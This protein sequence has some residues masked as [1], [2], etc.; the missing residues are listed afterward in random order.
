[1]EIHQIL[2]TLGQLVES[3]KD[4]LEI[5]RASTST[6]RGSID[7]HHAS[8]PDAAPPR[9]T[10]TT[11][12]I[13][14][15][16]A[17]QNEPPG[18]LGRPWPEEAA[19]ST[20]WTSPG[21]NDPV[22][23]PAR[24]GRGL[25]LPPA[26][27]SFNSSHSPAT[28]FQQGQDPWTNPIETSPAASTSTTAGTGSAAVRYF[29]LLTNDAVREVI[30]AAESEAQSSRGLVDNGAFAG[31]T[32]LQRA[33][34]IV[35][36]TPDT[37]GTNTYPMSYLD[38]IGLPARMSETQLWQAKEVIQLLPSEKIVF[39]NFVRHVSSWVRSNH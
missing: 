27:R 20:S 37:I 1:M 7:D 31:S 19:E 17:V 38:D 29:S 33:T 6:N 5:V 35:D 4:L 18:L 9:I 16:S 28:P 23:E 13:T 36:S 2:R 25:A 39:E 26:Q 22:L 24:S 15:S 10:T 14:P 11:G 30:Q 8:E 34:R 21:Y 32:S 3:Q 12:V